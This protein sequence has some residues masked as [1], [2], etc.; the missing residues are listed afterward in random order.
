M[1]D[2]DAGVNEIVDA[3]G[4]VVSHEETTQTATSRSLYDKTADGAYSVLR[5]IAYLLLSALA[6]AASIGY[7]G[8][9]SLLWDRYQ[10]SKSRW[11]ALDRSRD[12]AH[13]AEIDEQHE[14]EEQAMIEY[15]RTHH[16]SS[17][18]FDS[19]SSRTGSSRSS[20]GSGGG[21][22]GGDGASGSW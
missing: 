10:I 17:S 9:L 21:S 19:S 6:L 16:S 5:L 12:P 3:I 13:W 18:L 8:L 4:D 14:I 2:Y 15:R 20:T 11:E 7:V 22:F 1:A